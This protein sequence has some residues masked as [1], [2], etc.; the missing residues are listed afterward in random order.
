[1]KSKKTNTMKTKSLK[2][3]KQIV[4]IFFLI[5]PF[6]A[7]T[8]IE[9]SEIIV[10]EFNVNDETTIIFENKNDDV[11]VKVWDKDK[12]KLETT[13]AVSASDQEDIDLTLKALKTYPVAQ[14]S[15][16]IHLN[17]KFYKEYQDVVI[18][19]IRK[20]KIVFHDGSKARLKKLSLSYVLYVPAGN[21]KVF[22]T[23]Y[24]DL[25]LP[26]FSGKTEINMYSGKVEG[27]NIDGEVDIFLKYSSIELETIRDCD[28]DIYDSKVD[29][30]EST[31]LNIKSKYS[32]INIG[33]TGDVKFVCYTDEVDIKELASMDG[34]AKYSN[35]DVGDFEK[36]KLDLYDC[37]FYGGKTD[38]LYIKSKYSKMVFRSAMYF[39][40]TESYDDDLKI[41][42]VNMF[43]C[44]SKYTKFTIDKLGSQFVLNGYND[45]VNLNQI[46]ASF[47][48]IRFDGKY[49]KADLHFDLGTQFKL[50]AKLTYTDFDFPKESFKEIKYHKEDSKFEY[51]GITKNA[52]EPVN[53]VVSFEMYDG[54]ININL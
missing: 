32:E 28:L 27:H 50:N 3:R 15:T 12:I 17:T 22:K 34:N 13:V 24:C 52:N 48:K 29:I 35:F 31:E 44:S 10:R 36:G 8:Q 40:F 11:L 30:I 42:Y 16:Q 18:M 41:G 47:K 5:A 53:A 2:Y 23:K 51:S 6:I 7:F 1:M 20:N 25:K 14:S 43:E 21:H 39:D 33:K 4:A 54:S 49:I 45:D 26:N 37:N 46:N 9:T 19:G 38:E